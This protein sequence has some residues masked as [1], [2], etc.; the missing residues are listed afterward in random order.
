MV[1]KNKILNFYLKIKGGLVDLKGKSMYPSLQNGWKAKIAQADA[2]EMQVGDIVVF[3]KDILTCHRIIGKIKFFGKYYFIQKGD[4]S[5]IGGMIKAEDLI[6]KVME[7]FDE[8]GKR[9]DKLKW[10]NK[11][12]AKDTKVLY[13]LYLFLYFIKRC[14]WRDNMNKSTCFI[15]QIFWKLLL[16]DTIKI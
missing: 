6:G 8:C 5:Y 1:E 10:S 14:I 12:C 11:P 9:V 16:R 2:A 3:G 15:K 13:Y 4:H 7:V